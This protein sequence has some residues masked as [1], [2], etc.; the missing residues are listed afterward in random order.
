MIG[1]RKKSVYGKKF[2]IRKKIFISM[3]FHSAVEDE[4]NIAEANK[5]KLFD[6][7]THLNRNYRWFF[8]L[9]FYFLLD[10]LIKS[11]FYLGF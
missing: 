1:P 5:L 2:Q 4:R 3:I 7:I 10:K 9:F 6:K 8:L 11:R